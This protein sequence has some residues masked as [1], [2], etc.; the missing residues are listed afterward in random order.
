LLSFFVDFR[1]LG[2]GKSP[3]SGSAEKGFGG[4]FSEE[5]NR[6]GEARKPSGSTISRR[7]N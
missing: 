2:Q 3:G 6:S 5:K 7:K 4:R 1:L